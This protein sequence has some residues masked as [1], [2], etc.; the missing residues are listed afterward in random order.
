[1]ISMRWGVKFLSVLTSS[2]SLIS[3]T[4]FCFCVSVLLIFFIA[5]AAVAA[6]LVFWAVGAY[7]G[8]VGLRQIVRNAAKDNYRFASIVSKVVA[9]EAFRQREPDPSRPLR[10]ASRIRRTLFE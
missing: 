7:N 10:E 1:M 8:L 3:T 2:S 6:V 9:S 4:T 5:F